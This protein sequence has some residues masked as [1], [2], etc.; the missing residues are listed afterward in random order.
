M[1]KN[2]LIQKNDPTYNLIIDNKFLVSYSLDE[3]GDICISELTSEDEYDYYMRNI[4][5]NVLLFNNFIHYM[6]AALFD[7]YDF[8]IK[9]Q[10]FIEIKKIIKL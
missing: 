10:W 9:D 6:K 4:T 2:V 5:D 1:E 8:D 7:E 3:Q